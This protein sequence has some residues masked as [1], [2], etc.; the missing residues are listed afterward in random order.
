[1]LDI[2]W[3]PH[4]LQHGNLLAVATSTGLIT[5][6]RLDLESERVDL[7][8][9]T[10]KLVADPSILV[11]SIAWH[12]HQPHVIGITLSNGN[13]C[14]LHDS[15]GISSAQ[16][17]VMEVRD[18]HKHE[19]EAWTLAFAGDESK[20]VLSGGD[21]VVLQNSFI[22]GGTASFKWKDRRLHEAGV[23]AILPLT[24]DLIITGSYDDYIRLISTPA[25]GR[26]QV[27][28]SLNLGGGVWRMKS[29]DSRTRIPTVE[30]TKQAPERLPEVERFVPKLYFFPCMRKQSILRTHEPRHECMTQSD[31]CPAP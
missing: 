20:D 16:N 18:I 24:N 11:L 15:A 9:L 21:D 14:L 30:S 5:V 7:T 8:F 4:N 23:T 1:M 22:N 3:T 10:R 28:A 27:L 13:V 29:L 12:P 6:Y 31:M 19:L 25:A 17:E 2:Q 26:R